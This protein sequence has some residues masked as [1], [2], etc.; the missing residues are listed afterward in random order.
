[1]RRTPFV[2][3]RHGET[4]WN[5]ALRF[6]G[7]RDVPLN[8]HGRRQAARNGRAVSGIL[9]AADWR[10]VASPLRRSIE[11]MRIALEAAGQR[12]RSFATDPVLME[13][14]YGDWEGLTL[15][16]IGSRH[17]GAAQAREADKWGY[18]P[19]NGESYAMLAR[20]VAEW[21]KTLDAPTFVV[22]HG[23]VLRTLLHLLG[24]LPGHDAPHRMV[25]QDRV[26]L[27]TRDTVLTI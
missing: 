10:L 27:F 1:M 15:D 2:F 26:I 9:A 14:R 24:G 16:E 4:D 22:A 8:E 3:I 17:P 19:P 7:Q 21:L 20:R 11:T 12:G 5:R 23:G 13:V 6:Q 18:I 25:P